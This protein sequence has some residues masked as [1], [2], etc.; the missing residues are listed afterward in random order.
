M[1]SD[2]VLAGLYAR[3]RCL[4]YVPLVEG[5]GLPA[6]EAMASC[7]PVVASPMP[8]TAGAALEVDPRDIEAI[9]DALAIAAGD[10]RR[11]AELVTAGLVRAGELTWE[12]AARRH[13]EVWEALRLSGGQRW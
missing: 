12:A 8:S 4:A 2:P 9:A 13:V 6:V 7:I 1:V 5:W 11:R 3:A 10:D